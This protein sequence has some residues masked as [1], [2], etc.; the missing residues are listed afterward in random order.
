MFVSLGPSRTFNRKSQLGT[1]VRI[2][3]DTETVRDLDIKFV[4]ILSKCSR[5]AIRKLFV[6]LEGARSGKGILK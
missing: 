2:E 3:R 1:H 5:A 6:N 4:K